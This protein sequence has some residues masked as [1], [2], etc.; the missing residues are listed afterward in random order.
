MTW[1]V[2]HLP[3]VLQALSSEP[4]TIVKERQRHSSTKPT[5]HPLSCG[6]SSDS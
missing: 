2:E 6:F 5:R 1:V 3:S 4:I